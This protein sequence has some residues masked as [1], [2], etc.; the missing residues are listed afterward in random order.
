MVQEAFKQQSNEASLLD[1]QFSVATAMHM[2]SYAAIQRPTTQLRSGQFV[3]PSYYFH[4]CVGLNRQPGTLRDH[5]SAHAN[6]H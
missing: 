3:P 6:I 4:H 2:H 5:T 1:R